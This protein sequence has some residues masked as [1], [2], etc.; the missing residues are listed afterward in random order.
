MAKND[1]VAKDI[2][3][4][5]VTVA[6]KEAL[7]RSLAEKLLT[8]KYSGM[9][10][11]DDNNKII[12][13]VSEFDLLKVMDRGKS[14]EK[15]TAEEIM[16]AKPIFVAEDT[17]VEDIIRIMTK[18]N[19]IRVP[20]VRDGIPVGIISRCDIIRC[21]YGVLSP[22]FVRINS[23]REKIEFF[24]EFKNIEFKSNEELS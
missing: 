1:I 21:V 4:K 14:L 6:R 22:E 20:V 9:P 19:I 23:E 3:N 7:G 18:H 8:G 16:S 12:G 2:M 5:N 15:V 17:S 11:V 13:V 10:V 24:T